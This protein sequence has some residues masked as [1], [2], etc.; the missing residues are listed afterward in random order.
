MATRSQQSRAEEQRARSAANSRDP[1]K[2]KRK[3]ARTKP[4]VPKSARSADKKHAGKKATY[5]LEEPLGKRTSRK[6]TRRS[7]NRSKPVSTLEQRE[8][9]VKGTPT[10]RFRKARAR[11]TKPRGHG[12]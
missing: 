6:S 7:A 2:T 12:S 3:A 11:S 5:V 9:V 10:A 8:Q 4:G 1:R